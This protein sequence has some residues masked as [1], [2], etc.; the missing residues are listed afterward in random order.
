M[1]SQ[2]TLSRDE[3][4]SFLD[5]GAIYKW[6]DTIYLFWLAR[7]EQEFEKNQYISVSYMPFFDTKNSR[8]K[9]EKC[10]KIHQSELKKNC[11]NYIENTKN[12]DLV[13]PQTDN[14]WIEGSKMDFSS[15]FA[16]I[17][18]KISNGEIQK[19]VPTTTSVRKSRLSKLEKVKAIINLIELEFPVYIYGFWNSKGGVLGATPE[20]LFEIN[21]NQLTTMALA[22]T[23][24]S[25][26]LKSNNVKTLNDFSPKEFKEHQ[27][28]IDDISNQLSKLGKLSVE[29]TQVIEF[30]GLA[31]LKTKISVLSDQIIN[32]DNL[33]QILHPTPAL[34]VFPRSFGYNWLAELPGQNRRVLLGSPILFSLENNHHICLVGI[35]NIQWDEN[36][37]WISV[38]CGVTQ[39]SE[40]EK[41]WQ[42]LYYKKMSVKKI[43]GL[44]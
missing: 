13:N 16:A 34:G 17:Q 18:N 25:E 38:G 15:A 3:F 31:H 10:L 44:S 39:E 19:A 41:E 7:E 6:Q 33:I 27:F 14:Q 35:R 9:V 2:I 26:N 32:P 8:L 37:L 36:E 20:L 5:S 40:V 22:G 43:M 28:V 1:K 21:G 4:S 12:D 24:K 29:P 11:Q 23:L 42:E 30:P